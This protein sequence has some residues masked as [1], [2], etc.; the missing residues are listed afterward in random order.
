M[1][2]KFS[3]AISRF[4]SEEDGLKELVPGTAGSGGGSAP[5]LRPPLGPER[6]VTPERAFF[7]V[8]IEIL[9]MKKNP[10]AFIYKFIDLLISF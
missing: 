7:T 6:E 10:S 1:P 2:L 4:F 3:S 5:A 8:E 9:Q